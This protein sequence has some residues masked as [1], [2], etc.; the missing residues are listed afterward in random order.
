MNEWT[1]QKVL[2]Q[3]KNTEPDR[4]KMKQGEKTNNMLKDT[5][6]SNGPACKIDG[7]KN[8]VTYACGVIISS[9]SQ[10][11]VNVTNWFLLH[12]FSGPFC[13]EIVCMKWRTW[14][15]VRVR[16]TCHPNIRMKNAPNV[17]DN[18]IYSAPKSDISAISC[19]WGSVLW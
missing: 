5:Y 7:M 9:L 13:H 17:Y 11:F 19:R 3:K 14:V 1:N 15:S 6:L 4:K 8:S 10:L 12:C 18:K 2:K 16:D